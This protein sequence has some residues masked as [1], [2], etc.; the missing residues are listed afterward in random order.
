MVVCAPVNILFLSIESSGTH[1]YESLCTFCDI[2]FLL[3]YSDGLCISHQQSV[4]ERGNTLGIVRKIV[5]ISVHA[6]EHWLFHK[7]AG[8]GKR[9]YL[10]IYLFYFLKR[11]Y[12]G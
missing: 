3:Q 12:G 9:R 7:M 5:F 10:I 1:F 11:I 8:V 4:H 6:N 2:F